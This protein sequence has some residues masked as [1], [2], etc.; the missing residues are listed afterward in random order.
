VR[1]T[2][3]ATDAWIVTRRRPL[4][5]ETGLRINKRRRRLEHCFSEKDFEERESS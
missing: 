1:Q 2:F 4:D 3:V 5:A